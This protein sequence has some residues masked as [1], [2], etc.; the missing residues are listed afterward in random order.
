MAIA[1]R[2]I[3]YESNFEEKTILHITDNTDRDGDDDD[4]DDDEYD[5]NE[6]VKVNVS[7]SFRYLHTDLGGPTRMKKLRTQNF[8]F[9]V[10]K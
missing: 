10:Q 9:I 3:R 1:S 5:D 7:S 6:K 8:L 4:E 2:E